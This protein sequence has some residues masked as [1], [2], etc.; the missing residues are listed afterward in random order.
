[1][2]SYLL[3]EDGPENLYR[4]LGRKSFFGVNEKV[5]QL[6]SDGREV[7]FSGLPKLGEGTV[8]GR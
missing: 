6:S 1:M 3:D 5:G 7:W 2:G 8:L 4:K